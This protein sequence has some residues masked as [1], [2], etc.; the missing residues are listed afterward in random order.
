MPKDYAKINKEVRRE[1]L[2]EELQS[3]EYIRQAHA[4]LEKDYMKEEPERRETAIREANMKLG[5]YFKLLN[6]TL[7]DLKA[8]EVGGTDGGPVEVRAM[9]R[10]EY[11]EVRK[12]M[13]ERDDC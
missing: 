4:I 10:G 6:K 9:T 11:A 12:E 8:V 5:G 7:P 2:R 3:R 13:M 1:A